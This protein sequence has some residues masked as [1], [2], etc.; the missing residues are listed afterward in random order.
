MSATSLTPPRP[1]T[2]RADDAPTLISLFAG[3]GGLDLGLEAA[4]FETL[5]VND[6]EP[7]ALATL[8]GNQTLATMPRE[9]FRHWLALQLEQRCYRTLDA[10]GQ[11]ALRGRLELGRG[12]AP[13]LRKAAFIPGDIRGISSEDILDAAGL[14]PGQLSLLAGGPP[15]QP[16]SRAGKRE[17]VDHPDGLLFLEFVRIVRD[18][19]PRW[20]LF[21]NVKGLA[22]SKTALAFLDCSMCS[23]RWYPPIDSSLAGAADARPLSCRRCGS[24]STLWRSILRQPGGSLE[25][26][27]A[28]FSRLGY[29]CD[30]RILNAADFGVPQ[31]RER[32]IIVG[33]RDAEPFQWPGATHHRPESRAESQMNILEQLTPRRPWQGVIEAL[34]SD[35]HPKYGPLNLAQAVLWVKNVVRPHDEPVTWNLRRASPTIG[36]HQAAKLALA[37][38]GVSP[39]QLQ[40]QQWHTLGQRQGDTPPVPVVHEYLTDEELLKLQT[41]PAYWYLHGTR[42]QRAF[43]IGNAVPPILGEA[44]GIAVLNASRQALRGA[45]PTG[46]LRRGGLGEPCAKAVH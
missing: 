36:A 35:G 41:F 19:R 1:P 27:M 17:T 39:E 20:F 26:I 40:R 43:Q 4:G 29:E 33:S 11:D 42:M 22:Q 6:L 16:F 7:H 31:S 25:L 18:S 12:A 38:Y 21:E 37:P 14:V 28:E 23:A 9:E 34:W 3:A 44:V 24:R 30:S 45:T 8:A 46:A 15:C 13:F 32:V 5:A 10:E 2:A